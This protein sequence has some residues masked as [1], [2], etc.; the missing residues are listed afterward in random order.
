M[1]TMQDH[2]NGA[3]KYRQ[4]RH[5]SAL[6]GLPTAHEPQ[7]RIRFGCVQGSRL[8]LHG[9]M[10]GY[11][12]RAPCLVC[13][14]L[15]RGANRCEDHQPP[16]RDYSVRNAKKRETGQYSGDYR[17]RAKMVR[18]SAVIC[19]ICRQGYRPYDPWQADHIIPG[20]PESELA[21]AHRSCNASRGNRLL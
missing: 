9:K 13:G 21:P 20:N 8:L 7:L 11:N 6:S 2:C 14:K 12:F 4:C 15:T 5:I 1:L 16:K 19:H 10:K 3:E 17:R 18:D